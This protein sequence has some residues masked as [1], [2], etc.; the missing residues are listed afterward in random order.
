MTFPVKDFGRGT[1]SVSLFLDAAYSAN[2]SALHI[3]N[4]HFWYARATL[5][6]RLELDHLLAFFERL[7]ANMSFHHRAVLIPHFFLG[8][9]YFDAMRVPGCGVP[10]SRAG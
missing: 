3:P 2:H 6:T 10:D 5:E 9:P 4:P 1:Y 8:R 7:N